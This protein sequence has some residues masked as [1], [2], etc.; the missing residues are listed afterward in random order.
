MIR[1]YRKVELKE[2]AGILPDLVTTD[3]YD[4]I[5]N[6]GVESQEEF[7]FLMFW[8]IRAD[9]VFWAILLFDFTPSANQEEIIRAP[10]NQKTRNSCWGTGHGIGKTKSIEVIPVLWILSHKP[11]YVLIIAQDE[12]AIST[13]IMPGIARAVAASGF[14]ICDEKNGPRSLEWIWNNEQKIIGRAP[15]RAEAIAGK[16]SSGVDGGT[17]TI[18]DE[19][20]YLAHELMKPI[21][22]YAASQ[23]NAILMLGNPLNADGPFADILSGAVGYSGWLVK[24]FSSLQTPNALAALAAIAAGETTEAEVLENGFPEV[25]PGLQ[26][27]QYC[28]ISLEENG[29]HSAEYQSRVLGIVPDQATDTYIA[30]SA[31]LACGEREIRPQDIGSIIILA[32]DPAWSEA[33]DDSTIL[34]GD[35]GSADCVRHFEKHQ[36][37]G[38]VELAGQIVALEREWN[39]DRVKIENDATGSATRGIIAAGKNNKLLL[40]KILMVTPGGGAT[41]PKLFANPRAENWHKAKQGIKTLAIPKD[42]V[43]EFLDGTKVKYKQ[44][45]GVLLM[46]SKADLRAR[47]YKSPN[48]F[49]ALTIFYAEPPGAPMMPSVRAQR[50]KIKMKVK[51]IVRMID[52]KPVRIIPEYSPTIGLPGVLMRAWYYSRR[53]RSAVLWAHVDT[54]GGFTIF[55]A[56]SY[57]ETAAETTLEQIVEE[58]HKKSRDQDGNYFVFDIDVASASGAHL[59]KGYERDFLDVI[60]Q[61]MDS[62]HPKSDRTTFSSPDEVP[63]SRLTGT[64]GLDVLDRLISKT[65]CSGSE[66]ISIWDA[67]VITDLEDSRYKLEG[68]AVDDEADKQEDGICGP[69]TRCLRLLM[70]EWDAK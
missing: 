38:A 36:G 33:G 42:I 52:G 31:V 13:T 62:I 29:P 25:I 58:V 45:G 10:F 49:D 37:W 2:L 9:P 16:H 7:M 1:K 48:N 40:K 50:S 12:S 30:K 68:F 24:N 63:A 70:L 14:P 59:G 61:K 56:L 67:D 20:S 43:N 32:M 41:E 27:L 21:K 17:L 39:F 28:L 66:Q 5:E 19:A 23:R 55:Q 44:K 51:P 57:A 60:Y 65:P 4:I 22:S 3:A 15:N 11:C 34:I 69:L 8:G 54:Y 18:V 46:E 53:G 47:G 35:A 26:S 6:I 64:A